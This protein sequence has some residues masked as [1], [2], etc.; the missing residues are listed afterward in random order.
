MRVLPQLEKNSTAISLAYSD[1]LQQYPVILNDKKATD[2]S[3]GTI[4]AVSFKIFV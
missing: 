3:D 2:R 4:K 1:V